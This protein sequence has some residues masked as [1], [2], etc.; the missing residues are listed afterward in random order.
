M[1]G[2][3]TVRAALAFFW[4]E[5]LLKIKP[6]EKSENPNF[7]EILKIWL[8]I[9]NKKISNFGSKLLPEIHYF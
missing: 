3:G 8:E 7:G 6:N 4:L 1:D 5:M 2:F 9:K